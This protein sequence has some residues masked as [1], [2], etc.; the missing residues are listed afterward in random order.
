MS[1][2][3][4]QLRNKKDRRVKGGHPWVFSNEIDGDIKALPAGGAVG[5]YDSKG[6]FIGR[7][8]ANP[9]SLITVRTASRR[10]DDIDHVA[11]WAMKIREAVELRQLVYPGRQSMRLIHADADG[12]PGL[13]VDRYGDYLAVQ[14]TTLGTEQRK[15]ITNEMVSGLEYGD[16]SLSPVRSRLACGRFSTPR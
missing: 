16:L 7:G 13:V 8:Y 2:P 6:A 4:V 12:L 1:L 14:L 15:E 9:K 5:V 10:K 3:M 11:F